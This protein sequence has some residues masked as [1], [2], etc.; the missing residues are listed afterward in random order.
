MIWAAIEPDSH[1]RSCWK[2]IGQHRSA[3]EQGEVCKHALRYLTDIAW[4]MTH[5]G[6]TT[7]STKESYL[8]ISRTIQTLKSEGLIG[9]E[10][11]PEILSQL[12]SYHLLVT[13]SV[14]CRLRLVMARPRSSCAGLSE[15]TFCSGMI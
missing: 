8:V 12:L 13:V 4:E 15:P 7:I 10:P 6:K 9:S 1:T 2:R 11:D 5:A 14:V 3:L